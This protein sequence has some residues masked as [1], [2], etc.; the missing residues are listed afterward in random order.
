MTI[1]FA[2]TSVP[3]Q[4]G[5]RAAMAVAGG[6]ALVALGVATLIPGRRAGGA[7]AAAVNPLAPSNVEPVAAG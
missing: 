2:G 1:D 6:A 5:L 7:A 4:N 3:S